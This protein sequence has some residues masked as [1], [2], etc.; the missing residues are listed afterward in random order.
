MGGTVP[1]KMSGR[2]RPRKDQPLFLIKDLIEYTSDSDSDYNNLQNNRPYDVSQVNNHRQDEYPSTEHRQRQQQHQ[3][4][5]LPEVQRPDEYP[6]TD[7]ELL[8]EDENHQDEDDFLMYFEDGE[9]QQQQQQPEQQQVGLNG[10]N[11][12]PEIIF[13]IKYIF[14]T[15]K[16][17]GTFTNSKYK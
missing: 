9:Q 5:Q 1:G 10:M 17:D 4:E 14:I 16:P 7:E 2:G 13:S 15:L 3:H 8:A 11:I 6:H 12:F